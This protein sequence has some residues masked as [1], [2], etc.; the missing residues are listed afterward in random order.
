MDRGGVGVIGCLVGVK[1]ICYVGFGV[2]FCGSVECGF[3]IGGVVGD[4]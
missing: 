4:Y 1:V 3:G 2:V